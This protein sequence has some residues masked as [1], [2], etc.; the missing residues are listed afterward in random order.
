MVEKMK[1]TRQIAQL[2]GRRTSNRQIGGSNPPSGIFSNFSQK[3]R[4]SSLAVVQIAGFRPPVSSKDKPG[5]QGPFRSPSLFSVVSH[6]PQYH[7]ILKHCSE[8]LSVIWE[9]HFQ[10]IV[11]EVPIVNNQYLLNYKKSV[12]KGESTCQKS[13][14]TGRYIIKS[15]KLKGEKLLIAV[16]AAATAAATEKKLNSKPIVARY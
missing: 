1:T 3:P 12:R 15:F 16:A 6:S 14:Y 8:A 4:N 11:K 10:N 5:L 9:A 7:S 13:P 2:L